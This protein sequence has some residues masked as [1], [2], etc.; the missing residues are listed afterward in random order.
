MMSRLA[1]T[2]LRIGDQAP[3]FALPGL[4]GELVELT[5]A[6]GICGV[7]L[8][9]TPGAWSPATRRQLGEVNAVYEQFRENGVQVVVLMTQSEAA[10]RDRLG[11]YA[12][13][14]PILADEHREVA[15]QYG[16]F[17]AISWDGLGVTRPAAVMIDREGIIRF[18]YVGQRDA[19]V[20]DTES[21][22][23]LAIWLV[24]VAPIEEVPEPE[25]ELADEVDSDVELVLDED[26]SVVA[27][28]R[29]LDVPE[30][31]LTAV[32][33]STAPVDG[34][35]ADDRVPE[36]APAGAEIVANDPAAPEPNGNG[37]NG[38]GQHAGHP[39][40]DRDA[41]AGVDGG[42]RRA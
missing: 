25:L 7:V 8:L 30:D 13:P 15:R 12:I 19:D 20:P 18:I 41:E 32:T 36:A 3:Q 9:F 6:R 22:V 14:F 38:N 1:S 21:L 5:E 39:A 26:G 29:R 23:R 4:D 10:L 37:T 16:V 42:R 40:T 11:S 17:R 2:T 31:E 27:E 34:V 33:A 35:E 28:L 24:G